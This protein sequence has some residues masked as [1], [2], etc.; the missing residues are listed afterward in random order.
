VARL[1][2]RPQQPPHVQH[3]VR[4]YAL[5]VD[6][7]SSA[8][9]NSTGAFLCVCFLSGSCS[10]AS[11]IRVERVFIVCVGEAKTATSW[12]STYLECHLGF[13]RGDD[14]DVDGAGRNCGTNHKKPM[15]LSVGALCKRQ[16]MK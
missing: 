6:S 10:L 1:H 13:V 16:L 9:N 12:S 2:V 8:R 4:G 3:T 5:Q 15:F 14:R 7:R 11:F